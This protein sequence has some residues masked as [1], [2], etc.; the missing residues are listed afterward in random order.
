M[1]GKMVAIPA[2]QVRRDV[3]G[4]VDGCRVERQCEWK[5]AQRNFRKCESE[6]ERIKGSGGQS[7][8]H[9]RGDE[10]AVAVDQ[11]KQQRKTE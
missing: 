8:Q 4:A 10:Q 6:R 9:E 7:R 11:R 2:V 1:K 3:H 5:K